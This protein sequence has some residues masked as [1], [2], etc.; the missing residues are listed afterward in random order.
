MIKKIIKSEFL[1]NVATLMTGTAIAQAIPVLIS[2]VLSR[3]YT[4]EDFGI[5]ALYVSITAVFSVIST[6]RYELAIMLPEKEKDAVSLVAL[7][8]TITIFVS[9]ICLLLVLLFKE[10]ITNIFKD[11][12]ISPWL[13]FIPLF[14]LFAGIYQTFNYL[15]TRNKTFKKNALSKIMQTSTA[16]STNLALGFSIPGA[17]GLLIGFIV[18]RFFAAYIL[19]YKFAFS[20]KEKFVGITLEDIRIVA[21]KYYYF[22]KYNMPHALLNTLSSN[23]PILLLTS[24]FP[25]SFIGWYNFSV[26]VMLTPMTLISASTAQVFFQKVTSL[27]NEGKKILPSIKRIIKTLFFAGIIPV[28]VF[29]IFAP[30]LFS[31]VFGEEWVESGYYT[32]LLL[33]YFFMVF[34][35]S[36]ISFVPAVLEQQK[37]A[38][39][40]EIIYFILKFVALVVGIIYMDFKLSLILFSFAGI[41][42]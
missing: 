26:Y 15:S 1:K 25:I 23:F 18:G 17:A 33:P 2:P 6:G 29:M 35:V 16:G 30:D 10:P 9:I 7:S 3:L 42:M 5:L 4:P 38:F 14:V 32:Q 24:Y 27:S 40:L 28:I 34:I 8:M 19:A 31:F 11:P 39:V 21:R 20:I 12:G 41:I 13:I 22:P 36:T 37:K